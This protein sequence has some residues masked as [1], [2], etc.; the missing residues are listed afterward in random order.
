M[1][2]KMM[3]I[4]VFIMTLFMVFPMNIRAMD[5]SSSTIY[6]LDDKVTSTSDMQDWLNDYNQDQSCNSILGDPGDSN[7][8]A[9]LLQQV[10]GIIKVIG[11]LLV[12]VLSS[13]DFAK[14]I[15]K[16]D[17]DAMAKAKKKLITR[18]ILAA[19]LFF[20]PTITWTILETFNIVT[21]PTC[22]LQ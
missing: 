1:G 8:V 22:G 7:S 12:V 18:L 9:W 14:V 4:F 2:K 15:I 21:N 19:L 20:V 17:D 5:I 16:S 13:I 6:L 11:P 3:L 10:F